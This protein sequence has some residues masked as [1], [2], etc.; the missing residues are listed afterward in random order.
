MKLLLAIVLVFVPVLA[1]HD[2]SALIEAAKSSE[3]VVVAEVVEVH[4]SPGYW[5]GVVASV[6]HVHYKVLETLKGNVTRTDIDAGHYVVANSL[7]ADRKSPQLSPVLFK[8][9]NHVVLMLTRERGHSCKLDQVPDGMEAFC[10][11]NENTGATLASSALIRKL[12]DSLLA[13]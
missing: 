9:G 10:S 5:S 2:D 1:S 4:A 7:T 12:R 6:Q 11:R 3:V 8:P 13:K